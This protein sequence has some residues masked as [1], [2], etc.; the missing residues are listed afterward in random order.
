MIQFWQELIRLQMI[1]A[2][3]LELAWNI[4][5]AQDWWD[6]QLTVSEIASSLLIWGIK[7]W[8]RWGGV[9]IAIFRITI[10]FNIF[11]VIDN[12]AI[13]TTISIDIIE[14]GKLTEVELVT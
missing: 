5:E 7:H 2:L 3:D 1:Y 12:I 9:N 10:D 8:L 14:G 6:S 13:D 4:D 11:T